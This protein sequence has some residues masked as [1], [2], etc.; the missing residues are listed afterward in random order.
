MANFVRTNVIFRDWAIDWN[1]KSTIN[2]KRFSKN[3]FF[4]T[5]PITI[6]TVLGSE[7]QRGIV[8]SSDRQARSLGKDRSRVQPGLRNEPFT[9]KLVEK[10]GQHEAARSAKDFGGKEEESGG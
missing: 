2:P 9:S 6:S 5:Q 3:H 1:K 4:S 10:A 7:V 8:T